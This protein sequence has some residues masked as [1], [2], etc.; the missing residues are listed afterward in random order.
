MFPLN[1]LRVVSG[2]YLKHCSKI[3]KIRWINSELIG[4]HGTAFSHFQQGPKVHFFPKSPF[5]NLKSKKMTSWYGILVAK[6]FLHGTGIEWLLRGEK[7]VCTLPTHPIA[8]LYDDNPFIKW[9]S[10]SQDKQVS[11]EA[12]A[13][14]ILTATCYY[15]FLFLF[16]CFFI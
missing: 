4:K 10:I 11:V 16:E 2:S 5:V 1:E 8:F 9:T 6:L 3:I 15:L 12:I 14:K 13:S 7:R